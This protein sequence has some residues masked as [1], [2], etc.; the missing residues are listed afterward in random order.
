MDRTELNYS[1]TGIAL[2]HIDVTGGAKKW[3]IEK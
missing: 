3:L 2:D 1:D